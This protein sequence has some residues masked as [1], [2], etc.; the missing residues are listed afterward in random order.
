M[1]PGRPDPGI[2][3]RR[4]RTGAARFVDGTEPVPSTQALPAKG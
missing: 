4:P 1:T 2:F 3:G